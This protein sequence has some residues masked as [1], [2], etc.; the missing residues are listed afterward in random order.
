MTSWKQFASPLT[1][2]EAASVPTVHDGSYNSSVLRDL[3]DHLAGI[4]TG[5]YEE[6]EKRMAAEDRIR[7]QVEGKIKV[8][9][10]RLADVTETEMSRM[11]R[12][13]EADLADKLDRMSREMVSLSSSVKK[14]TNQVEL[15]TVES[16]G[17][18]LA[19][20]QLER[21]LLP[22]SSSSEDNLVVDTGKQEMGKL[23]ELIENDL[24]NSKKLE[25]VQ[26]EIHKRIY[27]RLESVEDWLKTNLTPEILRL[28]EKIS[29]EGVSREENNKYLVEL[30]SEYTNLVQSHFDRKSVS[31]SSKPLHRPPPE[32][33]PDLTTKTVATPP[34]RSGTSTP[35]Q[36]KSFGGRAALT[37]I[38][39]DTN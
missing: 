23:R 19:L 13:M 16:R 33:M 29:L 8:A 9:V 24:E 7:E 11:Y 14:L 20:T 26:E 25:D 38:M 21:R 22:N 4:E 12:R 1:Q 5:L 30:V 18:K 36:D 17:T 28:K 3:H 35:V 6:I 32:A 27:P 34:L 39:D 10:N 31:K 2:R 15:I 37:K